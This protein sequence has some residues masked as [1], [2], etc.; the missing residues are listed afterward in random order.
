MNE[1]EKGYVIGLIDGEG[2]VGLTKHWNKNTKRYM[3]RP[4]IEIY[5]NDLKI[6]RRVE[7][8]LILPYGIEATESKNKKNSNA[9]QSYKIRFVGLSHV[10]EL[11][12][13]IPI[14]ESAKA[15]QLNILK[16][17]CELRA[18]GKRAYKYTSEVEW[19]YREM[20]RLNK[21]GRS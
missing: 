21:R 3:Y 1:F 8:V 7:S 17:F 13:E 19:M 14:E 10:P 11:L 20:R 6:L 4:R 16:D 18:K 15:R 12:S 9:K 5:N 2:Y